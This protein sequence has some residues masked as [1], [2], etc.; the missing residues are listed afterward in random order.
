M[1]TITIRMAKLIDWL[2]CKWWTPLN[3]YGPCTGLTLFKLG[4]FKAELWHAPADFT[5]PEHTHECSDGEFT[6]LYSKNRRI[7]RRIGNTVNAYIANTP[8]AWGKFLSVR[9]GTPHAFGKGDSCMVWICF[10]KWKHGTRVT[11]VAEDFHLT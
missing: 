7:Y 3:R 5:P 6:I 10:E 4:R 1:Q 9:A 8:E 11:S 2:A